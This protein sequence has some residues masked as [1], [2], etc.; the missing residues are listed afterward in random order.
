MPYK[1]VVTFTDLED[2]NQ[3]VY[4]VGDTFPREGVKVTKARLTE[5]SS[6]RNK[7]KE[8]LIEEEE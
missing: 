1:V 7:R 4:R 6:K 5:L 2:K 3:H 8:V